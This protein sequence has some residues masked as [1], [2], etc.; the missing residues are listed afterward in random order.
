LATGARP[1]FFRE[2]DDG[3]HRLRPLDGCLHPARV[4]TH[5]LLAIRVIDQGQHFIRVGF[6]F[7]CPVVAA[8]LG[9]GSEAIRLVKRPHL[10]C[11]GL[12]S[13]VW[14]EALEEAMQIFHISQ[15]ELASVLIVGRVY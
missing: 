15:Q 11:K 12:R 5:L 9:I 4:A 8:E 6:A 10:L 14:G 7:G 1:G 13:P 3:A 2:I